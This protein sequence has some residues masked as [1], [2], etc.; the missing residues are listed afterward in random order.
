[1]SMQRILETSRKLGLPVIV[2]DIAGREPMVVLPLEQFE[3]MAGA[4]GEGSDV[5]VPAARQPAAELGE[6]KVDMSY[7]ADGTNRPYTGAQPL[8]ADATYEAAL[9]VLERHAE[10]NTQNSQKKDE[11]VEEELPIEDRFYIE[12]LDDVAG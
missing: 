1:M 5:A 6:N 7:R 3:A 4:G 2:T 10:Q 8:A 12:P 9:G 11:K